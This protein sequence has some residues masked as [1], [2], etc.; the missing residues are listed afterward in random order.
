[1]QSKLIAFFKPRADAAQKSEIGDDDLSLW[2]TTQHL[3]VNTYTRRPNLSDHCDKRKEVNTDPVNGK[4]SRPVS[5]NQRLKPGTRSSG[6]VLNKKR[7]YAQFHLDLGQSDFNLR[8]CSTCDFNYAPGDELDEKQHRSFHKNY[9][10]GVPFKAWRHE[11]CV[12][13]PNN[14]GGR[15]I[16]VLDGD[17]SAQRN[18]VQEVVKMMEI[19]LEAGWIFHKLCQ[20]YLFISSQ[21][22]AGCVV[23]EP[24]EEAF[25]VIPS[26]MDGASHSAVG[27]ASGSK[28]NI[29]RFGQ[30]LFHREVAKK[31]HPTNAV[32][33]LDA[34]GAIV[35]EEETVR[36]VCGIR[37]IWV[38]PSNRRRRIASQLLDA[39]R[40]SFS[41]GFALEKSELAF[42]P[43]TSSG[44][45]LASSYVGSPSF[46][47]YKPASFEC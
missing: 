32:G 20:V 9:T 18:K 10:H 15:V 37:A 2:E 31:L 7:S 3:F 12:Q 38:T 35:C 45:S 1:M 8:T 34:N 29:L 43:P 44:K 46:L 26:P 41:N 40:S 36:A 19:E 14:E 47:V 42:S 30:I 13:R 6:K 21:R 16:L 4:L 33:G 22:V 17:P 27:K 25:R 5:G 11:R 24:I 39:V 23:A 28:R